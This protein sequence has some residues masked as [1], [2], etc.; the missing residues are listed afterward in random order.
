MQT[1]I[2]SGSQ[3]PEDSVRID[4]ETKSQTTIHSSVPLPGSVIDYSEETQEHPSCVIKNVV[5]EGTPEEGKKYFLPQAFRMSGL[6]CF[7]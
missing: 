7:L 4:P 2:P 5:T 3:V 1:L 6:H